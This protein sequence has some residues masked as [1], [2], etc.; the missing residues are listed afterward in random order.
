MDRME[1]L[2]AMLSQMAQQMQGMFKGTEWNN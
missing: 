1:Q 2:K